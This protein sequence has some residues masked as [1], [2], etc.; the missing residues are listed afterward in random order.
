MARHNQLEINV[1]H[2]F[3]R[4]KKDIMALQQQLLELSKKQEEIVEI[5]ANNNR[6]RTN[7]VTKTRVITKTAK[8]KPRKITYI[9]AK[10]GKK[11]HIKDC[12]FAQNIQPK[13]EVVF[14]SKNTALNKGFKPCKCVK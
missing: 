9:A 11:F 12:P 8:S 13:H 10:T 6:P 4:A 3:R 7:T 14:K 2:S 5:V 1:L